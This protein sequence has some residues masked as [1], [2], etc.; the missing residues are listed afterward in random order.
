MGFWTVLRIGAARAG[1]WKFKL[2]LGVPE[3]HYP[4]RYINIYIYPGKLDTQ[5]V[6]DN[7]PTNPVFG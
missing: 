5:I 7:I 4:T 2:I 3:L 6:I 1:V